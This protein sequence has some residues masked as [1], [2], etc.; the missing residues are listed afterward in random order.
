[1][2]PEESAQVKGPAEAPGTAKTILIVSQV[3]VPD[4]AAVGQHMAD[5]AAELAARGHRVIVLTSDRGYDNPSI[6]Y[7]RSEFIDG[8]QVRRLPRSSF[9]KRSIFTR[10]FGAMAF[11]IQ[12]IVLSFRI[13]KIDVV[14]VATS[15]PMAPLAGWFV[16]VLRGADL[17]YWVMDL[18]PDQAIE[19][20][21][22]KRS[23]IGAHVLATMN[24]LALRRATDVVTLDHFMA[25]RVNAHRD[26]TAKLSVIPPWAI[27]ERHEIL[28]HDENPF[29]REHD[30]AGKLVFMYSGN[31]SPSNPLSTLLEAAKRM[32][33]LT[34]VV[35]M[36]VG[37]GVGMAEVRGANSPNIRTLPYQPK[38]V[39]KYSLA[40]ADVHIVSI[41]NQMVGIVHP[42]KAYGALAAG[43]PILLLGP[44]ESHIGEILDQCDVGWRVSHG[45]V[46]GAERLLR[47]IVATDP[48]IL[49]EMGSRA[50]ELADGPLSREVLRRQIC[51]VF[52]GAS[53]S[54]AGKAPR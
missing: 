41:G 23:S 52:A 46:D 4:P 37:G 7:S 44:A 28:H 12:A 36:F 26:V 18:N 2:R 20:G 17:K 39:L 21:V 27:D 14:I 15:P 49:A 45:D 1:M 19:L 32:T 53:G 50:R 43:R 13:P 11:V 40:A 3:Y 30:L 33:D 25:A 35:F 34:D 16:S 29:R 54:V 9:G 47:S 51:D 8:V 48:R 6:R 10:G 42:S 5:A 31:H 24:R 38:S 22:L